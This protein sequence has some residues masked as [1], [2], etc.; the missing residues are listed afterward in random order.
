MPKIIPILSDVK[1]R[2]ASPK[3]AADGKVT[4]KALFDG[5]VTGLHLL[6]Q[7]NGAKL[8][9]MKYL[10]NGKDTRAALPG[11]SPYPKTTLGEAREIAARMAAK[12]RQ[13]INPVS[14]EVVPEVNTFKMVAENF[15][16]WKKSV[17]AEAT[18]KKYLECLKNDLYPALGHRDIKDIHAP[19]VVPLLRKIDKRSN[20]LAKKCMDLVTMIIRYAIQGG[21][22]PPYTMIDMQGVLHKVAPKPKQIP[23]SIQASFQSIETYE[24]FIMRSA[25]KLQFLV[26]LR[27]SETMG[28][29]WDEFDFEKKEWEVPAVRMKMKRLHIVPLASQAIELLIELKEVTGNTPWLF[30]SNQ[31]EDAFCRDALSLAF[32]VHKLGIVPHGV[33]TVASTWLK[34]KGKFPP[35]II[36][37]QLSHIEKDKIEAAYLDKP[38]LMYL[39]ERHKAMQLWADYLH[40]ESK[41]PKSA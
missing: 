15:V 24:K 35:H 32:R 37:V 34:D 4:S 8:W 30:P 17:I 38:H 40:F 19:E 6:V 7:P 14:P 9:R 13:G 23:D 21:K 28:A 20:S 10:F 3:V 36:E 25:M 27:G 26:W 33:R 2:N 1:I 29:R 22:R 5:K 41:E 11:A 16:S 18:V 12:I 31:R 39:E